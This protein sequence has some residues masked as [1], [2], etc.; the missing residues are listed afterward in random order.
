MRWVHQN[1][2]INCYGDRNEKKPP[3]CMCHEIPVTVFCV[4][5]WRFFSTSVLA[6][7]LIYVCIH[8]TSLQNDTETFSMFPFSQC[9]DKHYD[10]FN[11]HDV[12]T[13]SFLLTIDR[14]R[15]LW[16]A[17]VL[18]HSLRFIRNSVKSDVR[19]GIAAYDYTFNGMEIRYTCS[20]ATMFNVLN[21][22]FHILLP[23]EYNIFVVGRYLNWNI[24]AIRDGNL[25]LAAAERAKC[26]LYAHTHT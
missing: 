12:S 22:Y 5:S 20:T 19:L 11:L 7:P 4:C 9:V 23:L 21:I 15:S 10:T 18:L 25:R 13:G 2:L 3:S 17:I 16:A 24:Y 26:K 14:E 8:R 1:S 6:L